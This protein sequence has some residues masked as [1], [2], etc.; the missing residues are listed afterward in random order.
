MCTEVFL[1]CCYFLILFVINCFLFS[2]LTQK[3][4]D[5]NH[6]LKIRQMYR[7]FQEETNSSQ[8]KKV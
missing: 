1:A 2:V 8:K 6:F 7:L 3:K 4:R 5:I